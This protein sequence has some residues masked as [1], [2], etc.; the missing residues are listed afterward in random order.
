MGGE[1]NQIERKEF[2]MTLDCTLLDHA[3]TAIRIGLLNE[4]EEIVMSEGARDWPAAVRLN[5]MGVIHLARGD[6]RLARRCLGNAFREGPEY[7]PAERNVRRRYELTTCGRTG[8]SVAM[9]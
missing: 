2:V 9:G 6:E 5:L 7:R 3:R 4:A 1:L 8:Q